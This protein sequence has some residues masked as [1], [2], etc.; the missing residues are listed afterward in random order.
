MKHPS[1][2][3]TLKVEAFFVLVAAGKEAS[4][5]VCSIVKPL[6]K[7]ESPSL[8]VPTAADR[9]LKDQSRGVLKVFVESHDKWRERQLSS[10]M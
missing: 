5:L 10:S 9:I 2:C 6:Q 1:L 3:T 8:R 4:S 7:T